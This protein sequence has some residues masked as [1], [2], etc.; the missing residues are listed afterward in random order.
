[1]IIGERKP[2]EEIKNMVLS[3]KRVLVVGCGTCVTVCMAGGEKEVNILTLSLKMAMKLEEKNVEF[4]EA[5]IIRQCEWEFIDELLLKTKNI[6]AILSLGCGI[7]VS[8]LSERFPQIPVYPAL[9]TSFLGFPEKQGVWVERCGACGDC[10]LHLTAGVCPVVRCSKGLFN[11][12]CGGSSNGKCEIS[13]DIDC[14]WHII[15]ERLKGL[16]KLELLEKIIPPKD[17]SNERSG[18]LRRITRED[19]MVEER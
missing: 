12:P 2:F 10:M 17:W 3:H 16:N 19:I 1:M 7:G 5:T 13:K 6:D 18:G 9:N 15:Y 14:A 8:C 4:Q 11:G